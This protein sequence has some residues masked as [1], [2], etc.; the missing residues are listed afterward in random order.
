[1]P[2]EIHR[3]RQAVLLRGP[4]DRAASPVT[5]IDHGTERPDGA[6]DAVRS[7]A[8][9]RRHN[10]RLSRGRVRGPHPDPQGVLRPSLAQTPEAPPDGAVRRVRR[11]ADRRA[12]RAGPVTRGAAAVSRPPQPGEKPAPALTADTTRR[13]VVRGPGGS[14]LAPTK[15]DAVNAN[16]HVI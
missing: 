7:A 14:R 4:A 1:S 12:R 11:V 10:S 6:R 9:P 15:G 3:L 16:E 13:M 2:H 8:E 5:G